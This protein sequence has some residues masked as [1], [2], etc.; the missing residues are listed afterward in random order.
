MREDPRNQGVAD[1]VLGLALREFCYLFVQTHVTMD[2]LPEGAG[3][4]YVSS[5]AIGA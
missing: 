5:E 1:G 3:W 4:Y 2:S